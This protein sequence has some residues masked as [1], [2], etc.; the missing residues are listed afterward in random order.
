MTSFSPFM[1]TMMLLFSL[2]TP[3]RSASLP[4]AS[5]SSGEGERLDLGMHTSTTIKI[6]VGCILILGALC[7]LCLVARKR[8]YPSWFPIRY[9]L[10]RSLNPTFHRRNPQ[11]PRTPQNDDEHEVY[12]G[13]PAYTHNDTPTHRN[14]SLG[15]VNTSTTPGPSHPVAQDLPRF[16]PPVYIQTAS[17]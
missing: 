3:T 17:S 16:P 15:L 6:T 11:P 8:N 14:I 4:S 10:P 2:I 12:P 13:P 1:A 7:C 5:S 9:S